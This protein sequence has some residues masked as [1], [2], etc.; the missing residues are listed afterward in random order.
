MFWRNWC[1]LNNNFNLRSV[2]KLDVVWRNTSTS[3]YILTERMFPWTSTA[4]KGVLKFWYFL[5][6]KF[7]SRWYQKFDC[8]LTTSLKG[9]L[10]I[11]CFLKNNFIKR[12]L[13][14][15]DIILT[16]PVKVFL[17]IW[18]FLKNNFIKR[19][20]YKPADVDGPLVQQRRLQLRPR[21]LRPL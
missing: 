9:V 10:Q 2:K 15:F 4:S 5:K 20:Y 8:I 3:Q 12:C 21:P 6:N 7:T 11:L 19:W 16:T 17:Q 1:S 18:C 14:K 13:Y